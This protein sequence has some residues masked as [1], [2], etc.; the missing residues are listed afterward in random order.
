MRAPGSRCVALVGGY[1]AGHIFPAIATAEWLVARGHDVVLL[2]RAEGLEARLAAAHGLRFR[3]VVAAPFV[4]R[5]LGGRARAVATALRG[6]LEAHKLLAEVA[7]DVVV[8]FGAFVTVGPLLAA[9]S[10]GIPRAL[11]EA[12]AIP[13]LANRVLARLVDRVLVGQ[14]EA[15]V[16]FPRARHVGLPVRRAVVSLGERDRVLGSG[17]AFR[18]LVTGGSLGARAL[19]RAAPI[20]AAEVALRVGPVE[21]RHQAEPQ[22]VEEVERAY[23]RAGVSA[24]VTAFRR[25][26]VS[27]YAWADVALCRAGAV[28]IAELAIVGLPAL[29]VPMPRVAEHQSENAARVR[30]LG[31][32]VL[33]EDQLARAGADALASLLEPAAH[34]R[35]VTALR[36]LAC[37]EAAERLGLALLELAGPAR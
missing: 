37:P 15:L 30:G 25:D 13:G 16:A 21:V 12:N 1:T 35:A 17:R 32:P 24:E 23:R 9:R 31:L 7:P 5:S 34:A 29:F 33:P 11:H 22:S 27:D 6:T 8:G 3:A 4:E 19:D 20:L 18:L 26:L 2:G 36:S 28:T 14:P 10:R